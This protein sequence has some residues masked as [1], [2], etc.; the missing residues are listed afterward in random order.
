M[1]EYYEILM[2][3]FIGLGVA[4]VFL[5]IEALYHCWRNKRG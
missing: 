4:A 2:V 3:C 5:G 1:N